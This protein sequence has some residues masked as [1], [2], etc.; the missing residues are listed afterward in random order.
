[1]EISKIKFREYENI[2][3]RENF[4]LEESSYLEGLGFEIGRYSIY[5]DSYN[6]FDVHF[7]TKIDKREDDWFLVMFYEHI[8]DDHLYYRLD[9]F[10]EVKS[11]LRSKRQI[12]SK[13]QNW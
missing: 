1:M 6:Y 4:T 13:R 11:F 7:F 12:N 10:D 8:I 5:E 9:G 2:Y 3:K